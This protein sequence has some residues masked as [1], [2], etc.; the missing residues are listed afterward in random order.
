MGFASQ[1]TLL[2]SF[3]L[4]IVAGAAFG[5]PP[6]YRIA[7]LGS[8]FKAHIMCS[9]VFVSG[10]TPQSLL[11]AELTGPRYELLNFFDVNVDRGAKRVTS[12]LFGT[13]GQTAIFREG[14]GCT[15]ID[16]RTE[17]ELRA[18]IAGLASPPAPISRDALWPDGERVD[19]VATTPG[20]DRAALEAAIDA[21]FAEP[22]PSH[23][24][25]TRAM[26]VVHDGRIVAERYAPGFDAAMPLIGWSMTKTATAALIGLA[27]KDG[28]LRIGDDDLVPEWRKENDPRRN[29][30]LDDLLQMQ[31]GLEFEEAY[32]DDLSDV[33]QM[34][35]VKGNMAKFAASKPLDHPPG[36][37]WHYS[38]GTPVIIARVLGES[39]SDPR[40][41]L[42]FPREK[43]FA[44]LGMRTAVLEP[45]AS[46]TLVGASFMFASA[47]DWARLGLLYLQNGMW[48][49]RQL[50]PADWV[51]YS[52]KPASAA[53][54]QEYGA[55]VWLK[56][57]DSEN[58]GEPPMPA[59]AYYMLGH[60]KQ[61]IAVIPSRDLVIVRLGLTRA[62]AV[63][64][65]AKELAPIVQAF[66]TSGG[67]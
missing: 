10:R 62:G 7:L 43:L 25:R 21:A 36:T 35:F 1:R 31:S 63:W 4:L 60:D 64:D 22:D 44:P 48:Q 24:R 52:L 27:V 41:Y 18:E 12:S 8:G 59:D 55:C 40:N 6:L 9:G 67:R 29:I 65:E 30:T 28:R 17:E 42:R 33:T 3:A 51:A 47:R 50:L 58:L 39:F 61:V 56:L 66:P 14:L 16:G 15:L 20:I 57:T 53:P 46:G 2:W 13:I 19:L 11:D 49:G 23:P 37:Y 26:V 54:D 38:S 45:D 5:V 32:G 34:L